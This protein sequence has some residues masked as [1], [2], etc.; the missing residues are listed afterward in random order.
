[1]NTIKKLLLPFTLLLLSTGCAATFEDSVSPTNCFVVSD[2]NG[3]REVCN[4]QSYYVGNDLYYW[5]SYYGIWVGPNG[6]FRGAS[7]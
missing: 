1:M 4:T 5:D 7:I 2:T 6:Y 3:E